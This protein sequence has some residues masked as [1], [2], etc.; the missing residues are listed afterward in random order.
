[1]QYL[2]GEMCYCE[3]LKVVIEEVI[4]PALCL[5]YSFSDTLKRPILYGTIPKKGSLSGL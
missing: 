4:H 1:M 3:L 5:I 2:W